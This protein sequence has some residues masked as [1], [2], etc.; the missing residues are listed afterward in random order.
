MN[1]VIMEEDAS[2]KELRQDEIDHELA[3][4]ELGEIPGYPQSLMDILRKQLLVEG[5][6][7]RW[8]LSTESNRNRATTAA[9]ATTYV[10][11]V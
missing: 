1:T 3:W 9:A 10:P 4:S 2:R 8:Q 6:L 5:K 7:W 11:N